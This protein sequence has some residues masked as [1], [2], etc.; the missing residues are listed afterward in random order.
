[1]SG[2]A[3]NF[4]EGGD[5]ISARIDYICAVLNYEKYGDF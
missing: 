2:I 4:K 1:M 5:M 3:R